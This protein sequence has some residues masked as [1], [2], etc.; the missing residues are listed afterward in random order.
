MLRSM[1]SGVSGLRIHQTKLDVIGNNIANVN[2]TG[3]KASRVTFNEIFSQTLQSASGGSATRGGTNPMQIGLGANIASIDVQMTEGP[4]QRTDNP[5]DLKIEGEGFFIVT[6]GKGYK[7]TRDG[8]FKVDVQGN[9]INSAGYRVCGWLTDP[10]TGEIVKAPA[11]PLKVMT[12]ETY[13]IAPQ[14][15]SKIAYEKNLNILDGDP[16]GSGVP[17]MTTFYDSLGNK[18][19]AKMTAKYYTNEYATANPADPDVV[20]LGGSLPAW[21][22]SKID[23]FRDVNG[24]EV[25]FGGADIAGTLLSAPIIIEF[26]V[27]GKPINTTSYGLDFSTVTPFDSVESAMGGAGSV[28]TLDFSGLTQYDS[29]TT[30][31]SRGLDG[32]APGKFDGYQIGADGKII[33]K[34][35]NGESKILGQIAL[36]TFINPAGLQKVGGNLFE[37]TINSGDFDGIGVDPLSVGTLNAGVLEASNVDLAKEFTEM[38]TAQRGFQANSKIITTS[39]QILDEL[40]NL[41]R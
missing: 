12:A 8:S 32:R 16:T 10:V 26:D 14:K 35:D 28:V 22:I 37:T 18:Y 38:I 33:V 23:S 20:A 17:I 9:L 3:F 39:D 1:Y 24:N 5:L 27:S 6:D 31:A 29:E 25:K 34:Y 11:E 21:S 19:T 2:T 36:A 30:I 15:T 13:T 40:T 7:F 4:A 41:K